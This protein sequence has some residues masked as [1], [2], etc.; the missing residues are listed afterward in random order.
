MKY[1]VRTVFLVG[2]AAAFLFPGNASA[3]GNRFFIG[4]WEGIDTLEGSE[5]LLSISDNNRDGILEVRLTDTFFATCIA[6]NQGF[7]GSPGLIEGTGTVT[8]KVLNW[9]FSFKCYKPATNSLVEIL[10]GT[11]TYEA[12][13]K[14]NIL[15][16]E[17]GNIFHRVSK[18]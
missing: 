11:S 14:D 5:M 10:T 7:A 4:F 1:L 3:L 16:D 17:F 18:R 15:V 8:D 12:N 13:R 9:N 6:Q 2:L